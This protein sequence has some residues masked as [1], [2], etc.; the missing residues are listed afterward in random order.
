MPIYR[1][2]GFGQNSPPHGMHETRQK[3]KY[4]NLSLIRGQKAL[5]QF[6]N[7]LKSFDRI[8]KNFRDYMVM[9]TGINRRNKASLF[10]S[11][12]TR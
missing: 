1:K 10:L 7:P 3:S 5:E 6:K 2:R 4:E 11:Q 8:E 9:D 12:T